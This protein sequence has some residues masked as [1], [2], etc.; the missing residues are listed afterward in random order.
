MIV[1]RGRMGEVCG[2]LKATAKALREED[3]K[4]WTQ[5]R[6]AQTF[7]VDQKTVSRWEAEWEGMHN[8][9][10]PNTQHESAKPDARVKLTA[11]GKA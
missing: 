10:T 11:D 3:P 7:G 4:K 1:W 5:E 6:L 9:Q 2:A 8:R